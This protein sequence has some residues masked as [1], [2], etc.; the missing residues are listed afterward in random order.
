MHGIEVVG[1]WTKKEKSELVYIC[2]FEDE[3]AMKSAWNAFR[4]D[5]D[6]AAAREKTEANG[7]IVANVVSEIL[8][9]TSFSPMK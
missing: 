3:D 9:P 7:P 5:P 8:N 2:R 6:W 1:F 4:N